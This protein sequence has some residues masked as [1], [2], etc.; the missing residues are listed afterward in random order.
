MPALT[1]R[2]KLAFAMLTMF[3]L[4]GV[5]EMLARGVEWAR[6]WRQGEARKAVCDEFHPLRYDFA[7]GT[8]LPVNGATA[9]IN[10][11][12]LRG[13]EPDAVKQR[14]RVL[15]L[16]DSCTFGYAPDVDDDATYPAA[17]GRILDPARFEVLNGGR[18]GYGSLD[19][20]DY[21]VYHGVELKP[22]V[23]VILAGWNDY[24][25]AHPVVHRPPP[26]DLPG[27]LALVRLTRELLGRVV[28]PRP[29]S[30]AAERARVKRLATPGDRL[31]DEVFVRT[32]RIMAELVR[33][34]RAHGARPI[35]VTYANFTRDDWKGVDSLTD[36]EF[37]PALPYLLSEE[38]SPSAWRRYVLTTND[39]I[40][41]VAERLNVPLVDGDAIRDPA[42]FSDLVHL[43]AKGCEAL[44]RRVAPLVLK[45]SKDG[46]EG[47]R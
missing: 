20:L 6:W 36:D 45:V 35:L 10:R 34:C 15:C 43:K 19:V 24:G 5:L 16:G 39:L 37:R 40:R 2:K 28:R 3:A 30:L 18:P 13:A 25:Q 11:A 47:W 33:A 9:R 26:A 27:N 46:A 12:G 42:L 21:F 8:S 29:A 44:A 17:L 22:D 23:V 31:A 32:E 38:L 1:L 4:A 41:R 7:P 14:V